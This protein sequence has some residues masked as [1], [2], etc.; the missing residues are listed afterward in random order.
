ML[1][2]ISYGPPITDKTVKDPIFTKVMKQLDY[3][4]VGSYETNNDRFLLSNNIVPINIDNIIQRYKEHISQFIP[5][6]NIEALK[7]EY[8]V[9][10]SNSDSYS[11]TMM[12]Y[13]ITNN[14]N[15]FWESSVSLSESMINYMQ[16]IG[17]KVVVYYSIKPESILKKT[18]ETN[19][20]SLDLL[21]NGVIKY[22]NETGDGPDEILVYDNL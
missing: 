5:N 11:D 2:I 13:A 7:M 9:Q 10:R 6:L 8:Y 12:S 17:Y 22:K 20:Y 21:L 15:I 3:N 4:L 19:K 1:F 18:N 14:K 16:S